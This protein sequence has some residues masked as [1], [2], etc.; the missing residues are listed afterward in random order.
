MS[1]NLNAAFEAWQTLA[2]W[3]GFS[4]SYTRPTFRLGGI[5]GEHLSL[6]SLSYERAPDTLQAFGEIPLGSELKAPP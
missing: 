4:S 5:C 1:P 3:S 6:S 2:V